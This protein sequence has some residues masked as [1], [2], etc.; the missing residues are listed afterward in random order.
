[1][2][3]RRY[4]ASPNSW[5]SVTLTQL[6]PAGA[7][8]P[9]LRGDPPVCA[10][11]ASA[12]DGSSIPFLSHRHNSGPSRRPRSSRVL[13]PPQ[14]YGWASG[15][16]GATRWSGVTGR[17]HGSRS[18]MTRDKLQSPGTS[19]AREGTRFAFC[20]FLAQLCLS[21]RLRV[22]HRV[23]D[24]LA[25]PSGHPVPAAVPAHRHCVP[26]PIFTLGR[27]RGERGGHPRPWPRYTRPRSSKLCTTRWTRQSHVTGMRKE[28]RHSFAGCAGVGGPSDDQAC[29]HDEG[30]LVAST[31]SDR[32]ILHRL[33]D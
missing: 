1:M 16:G 29:S 27:G 32:R 11:P 18:S 12:S 17:A 22:Q 19:Y 30:G 33:H 15:A 28:S 5:L 13:Y 7:P 24:W 31:R 9:A 4:D 3:Q 26:R 10:L 14:I 23:Q 2:L 25:G 6:R 20:L 21:T 8:E